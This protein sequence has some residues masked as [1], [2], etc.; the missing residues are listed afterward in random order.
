[1]QY[2]QATIDK[3][4]G[5]LRSAWLEG[6]LSLRIPRR[7][8]R[9]SPGFIDEPPSFRWRSVAR[10]R[11]LP[12]CISPRQ[13]ITS[14]LE[15]LEAY[16][17]TRYAND[18]TTGFYQCGTMAAALRLEQTSDS[19]FLSFIRAQARTLLDALDGTNGR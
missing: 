5:S 8:F 13:E 10:A 14:V 17:M 7:G 12:R 4:F 11:L 18:V 1:M 15:D 16:L 2:Y 9:I 3:Q 6:L 19:R